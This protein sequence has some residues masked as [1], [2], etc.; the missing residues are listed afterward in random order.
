MESLT[1]HAPMSGSFSDV[2]FA[3][4]LKQTK[5]RLTALRRV[6]VMEYRIHRVSCDALEGICRTK[7]IAFTTVTSKE[8]NYFFS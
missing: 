8:D 5:N 7:S 1:L 3:E 2:A 4:A 6:S